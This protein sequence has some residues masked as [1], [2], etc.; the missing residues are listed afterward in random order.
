[1]IKPTADLSDCDFSR[2]QLK[3]HVILHHA[4]FIACNKNRTD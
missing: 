1:M 4:I 2:M 3:S